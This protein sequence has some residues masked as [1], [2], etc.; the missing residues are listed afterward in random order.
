MKATKL[1]AR[2]RLSFSIPGLLWSTEV[3]RWP[4]GL[5]PQVEAGCGGLVSS[6]V[7]GASPSPPGLLL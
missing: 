4:P 1:P 7:L 5:P 2:A 6:V 3:P